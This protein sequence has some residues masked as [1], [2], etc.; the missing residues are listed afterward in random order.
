MTAAI[1]EDMTELVDASID[2]VDLVG[3][4]AN[5]HRFIMAKGAESP[6]LFD[7]ADIRAVLAGITKAEDDELGDAPDA[8]DLTA[9]LADPDGDAP[10]DPTD[11]GSPAWEAIDAA[12]AAKWIAVLGRAMNGITALAGREAMES[13][14]GEADGQY[15]EWDLQDA[16]GALDYAVSILAPYAIGEAQD[17]Q[18]GAEAVEAIGKACVALEPVLT[19]TEG[20]TAITKAGR[21]LSSANEAALLKAVEAIQKVLAS[22][23]PAPDEAPV[24][25]EAKLA[26]PTVTPAPAVVAK[27]DDAAAEAAGL[28]AVFDAN[29]KLVGVCDPTNIQPITGATAAPAADPAPAAEPAA[30]PAADAD[31]GNAQ[32]TS[33]MTK[34]VED[35]IRKAVE[36]ATA[37]LR[38]QIETLENTPVPTGALL[39]G[40]NPGTAADASRLGEGLN[41]EDMRKQVAAETDPGN[42]ML[43]LAELIKRTQRGE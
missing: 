35:I 10:G 26:E 19:V 17:S 11:P 25:K 5:G 37:P 22:L 6:A 4:A 39:S 12:T 36:D 7:P 42:K 8:V 14:A 30:D 31:A 18:Y 43:G 23:P 28:Q 40:H 9:P 34:T 33:D 32:A 27:A 16:C 3:K 13:T 2:R 1:P 29:G 21:S 38:K 15:N 20:I 41:R 24:T